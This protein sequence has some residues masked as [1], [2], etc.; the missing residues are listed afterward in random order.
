MGDGCGRGEG[1][2]GDDGE[3]GGEGDG[4]D[5]REK[6]RSAGRSDAPAQVEGEQGNGGVPG[7]VRRPD[8]IA[9]EHR[10]GAEAEDD[11][12]QVEAADEADGPDDRAAGGAGGRHGGEAYEDVRQSGRGEDQRQ[13]EADEVQPGGDVVP[14]LQ[15]GREEVATVAAAVGGRGEQGGDVAVEAD[16]DE[17][18]QGDRAGQ[19][20]H[21]LDDLDPRGGPHAAQRDVDDHQGSDDDHG[22]AAGPPVGAAQQQGHQA[23]RADH[24]GDEVEHGDGDGRDAGGDTDGALAHPGDE[25]VGEGE[26][27]AVADQF[28]DEEQHDEPGDEE[29][30]GVEHAVVAVEGDE[31][32]DAEEGG[33]GHVVAGDGE[34]VLQ[35]GEQPAARV[36]LLG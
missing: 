28:G 27:P 8:G 30:D 3:D 1:D 18:G 31:P 17:D 13:T 6:N 7:G 32:G 23:A 15:T 2:A 9:P 33:G 12:H 10:G 19:Q 29:A 34:T 20:Q 11:G 21:G 36:E 16:Q 35:R 26:P 5:D 4:R 14:V 22:P 25:D 24:L